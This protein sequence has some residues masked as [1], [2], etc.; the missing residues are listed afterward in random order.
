[1][2]LKSLQPIDQNLI[3]IMKAHK[4]LDRAIKL[5]TLVT[6]LNTDKRTIQGRIELLQ[7]AGCAIGSTDEGYFIPTDE[8]ERTAGITKKENMGFS[9]SKAVMGYRQAPLS[10]IDDLFEGEA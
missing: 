4:G 1:M 9:I 8:A 7:R 10:W 3:N 6:L 5:D 2:K